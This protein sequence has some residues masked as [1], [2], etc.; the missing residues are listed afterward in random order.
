MRKKEKGNESEGYHCSDRF[1]ITFTLV[2]LT[3]NSIIPTPIRQV[4]LCGV[5]S[6]QRFFQ[7]FIHTTGEKI[8]K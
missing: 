7:N 1:K 6:P 4:T 8:V 5:Q 3:S 2:Q